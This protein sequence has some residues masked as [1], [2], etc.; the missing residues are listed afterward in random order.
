M[1]LSAADFPSDTL[2]SKQLDLFDSIN[3]IC[4]S[5]FLMNFLN[6]RQDACNKKCYE[7][8]FLNGLGFNLVLMALDKLKTFDLLNHSYLLYS[9]RPL[10][11]VAVVHPFVTLR[12]Y[13]VLNCRLDDKGEV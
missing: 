8:Y 13:F 9:L 1:V 5:C 7:S 4:R 11:P 10:G 2:C 3:W 12:H 6:A